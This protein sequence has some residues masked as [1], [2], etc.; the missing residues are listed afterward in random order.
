MLM[1]LLPNVGFVNLFFQNLITD[2]KSW[3]WNTIFVLKTLLQ[4]GISEPVFD[5][6]LVYT[7]NRIVWK[8]SY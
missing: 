2:T 4:Q 7:F 3:L 5:G 6:D 8:P 1:L